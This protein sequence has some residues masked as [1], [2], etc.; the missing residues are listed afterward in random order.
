MRYKEKRKIRNPF[1]TF[2]KNEIIVTKSNSCEVTIPEVLTFRSHSMC[3]TKNANNK[4][5]FKFSLT[6][7]ML[8]SPPQYK[9]NEKFKMNH[10]LSL[11]T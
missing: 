10:I 9:T 11:Y 1:K 8:P 7:N 6:E 3:K 4:I 2:F 5:T